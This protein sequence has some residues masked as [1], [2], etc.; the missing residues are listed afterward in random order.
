MFK[1]K[2]LITQLDKERILNLLKEG[3]SLNSN[4]YLSQVFEK[5]IKSI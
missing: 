1:N 5:E 4:K 2:I 3:Y